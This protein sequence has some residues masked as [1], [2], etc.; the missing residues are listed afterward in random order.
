M[1]SILKQLLL[2]G[3]A[4]ALIVGATIGAAY[5]QT[6]AGAGDSSVESV[7]V[8]ASR[9]NIAGFQSPTPVTVIGP[10][11][12][13]RNARLD[14]ADEIRDLP[15]VSGSS[16]SRGSNSNNG[17]QANA[18]INS[19]SLRNL[20]SQRNLVLIDGQRVVSAAIQDGTVDLATVPTSM[21][22]RV[23]VVTGGASAAWGSDAVTG[24]VNLVIN[25]NFEG[26]KG[27]AEYSDNLLLARPQYK[28]E[29]A[30]GTGFDGDR[31]HIEFAYNTLISNTPNFNGQNPHS[32]GRAFVYNPGYCTQVTYAPGAT[33]NGTCTGK[34]GEPIVMYAFATSGDTSTQGGLI[35]ANTAG[36]PGSGL[37]A[38]TTASPAYTGL[39]GIDFV[40]PNAT[41]TPFN[42][43]TV[44]QTTCYNG[45]TN[46]QFSGVGPWF[47]SSSPFHQWTFFNYT[48]Y[49]VTPDIKASVQ[50]NYGHFVEFST[51]NIK[52]GPNNTVYADNAYLDPSIAQRFVCSGTT[53]AAGTTTLSNGYNPFTGQGSNGQKPTQ[54]LT[55][56]WDFMNNRVTPDAAGISGASIPWTMK[57]VCSAIAQPCNNEARTVARGVF[58][59]EGP[60]PFIKDWNWNAS[61]QTSQARVHQTLNNDPV[62]QRLNNA[63]DAVRVT[64]SNVGTSGLPIGSIQCRGL[65][66]GSPR[67][68]NGFDDLTGCQPLN[69]FGYGNVSNQARAWINPGLN[70]SSTGILNQETVHTN[71]VTAALNLNG[72]LP[73]K[74]PAGDV[75][76]A[77]GGEYRLEQAGQFNVDPRSAIAGYQAGNFMPWSGHL[78]VAEAYTEINA[79]LLKN[80]IVQTLDIDVAGRITNYASEG[81]TNAVNGPQP[82]F[83]F[84]VE[85]WKMGFN[86]QINDD[87]RLRGFYSYDIRAP[88]VYDLYNPGNFNSQSCV[89]WV[90][91]AP[92]NPCFSKNGGNPALVPEKAN[93]VAISVVMTPSWFDGFTASLDWYDLRLHGGLT[94]VG[95]GT[96]ITR[97]K[98]GDSSYCSSIIDAAGDNICTY[99]Q[100]SGTAPLITQVNVGAVNASELTTAGLDG[101]IQY[102]FPFFAGTAILSGAASYVYDWSQTL[103]GIHFEG[104][105]CSGCFYSGGA[106]LSGNIQGA[107]RQ[108]AWNFGLQVHFTGPSVRD[109]GAEGKAGISTRTVTYTKVNGQDIA[110]ISSGQ[111]GPDYYPSN[112]NRPSADIGANISYKWSSDVQLYAAMD[113]IF[114]GN[115]SYRAGFRFNF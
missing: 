71:Q 90:S 6:P 99:S 69:N 17:S 87:F 20:G 86:S 30:V 111:A 92:N 7:E 29:V 35:N 2:G 13:E 98:A 73:W 109:L 68:V 57:N 64:A 82:K 48:S 5:A 91:G 53:C 1:N 37:V 31:G 77:L 33:S 45:C 81:E 110:A 22:Q 84:T 41:P 43:G 89:N 19:L 104:A 39:R 40:G 97:A 16:A 79:P 51:A 61:V 107:Y 88:I 4:S 74:L 50:L 14:L 18:G 96:V 28:A 72:V 102:N 113:R 59:L 36:Q 70:P 105:G 76:V 100:T 10:E 26:V 15:E 78:D 56:G 25:K 54:T 114:P 38:S 58:T 44:S 75:G 55:V 106:R 85:T 67:I 46:N 108:G 52:S 93:T 3:S 12:I 101:K 23:D 115:K 21:V 47:L 80:Q 9:I 49:Q 60:L 65:L 8:S 24:V 63:L 62:T 42:Y 11:Q 27:N 83:S 95:F 103:N 94:T 66:I 112:Y 32:N 34:T